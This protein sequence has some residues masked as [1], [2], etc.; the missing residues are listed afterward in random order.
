MRTS[1]LLLI[2][3]KMFFWLVWFDVDNDHCDVGFVNNDDGDHADFLKLLLLLSAMLMM[4]V[5]YD[6]IIMTKKLMTTTTTMIMR[7]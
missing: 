7:F 5:N 6:I 2:V 3:L 1:L 4:S